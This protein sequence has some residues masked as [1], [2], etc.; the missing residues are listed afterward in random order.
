MPTSKAAERAVPLTV[1]GGFLGAGKTSL[2]NHLLTGAHGVRLA[3]LVN[4]FGALAV[5]EALIAEHGG[6]TIAFANGCLC[7]TLGDGLL[8]TVDRLLA[9][10]RPPERI[11]VEASGV[12]D[13]RPISDLA[14]LHPGLARDLTVV[15]ADSE[16]LLER[17]RD[18]RLAET[19]ER[20]LAAADLVVLNKT[21]LAPARRVAEL[22]QWIAG[23]W[24]RAAL[25]AADHGRLPPALLFDSDGGLLPEAGVAPLTHGHGAAFRSVTVRFGGP[26]DLEALRA[27]LAD[28]PASVLRAKGF[29]RSAGE[30]ARPLLV[31]RVGRRTVVEQSACRGE[32]D[33]ALV[34]I[35]LDAMPPE[36]WFEKTFGEAMANR[37]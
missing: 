9:R 11:L 7:C 35:G 22:R 10:A 33:D 1:V 23:R 37:A 25:V 6:D 20:Q 32:L 12:A 4:D 8:T 34:F 28:L 13:P 26:V 31:Q 15:L 16:S 21:D 5:D 27:R 17:A 24:P 3:V 18:P 29:V 36:P 19:V 14:A 2:L 30:P